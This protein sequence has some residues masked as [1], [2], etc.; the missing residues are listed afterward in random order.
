MGIDVH[1]KRMYDMCYQEIAHAKQ[2][3]VD[4]EAKFRYQVFL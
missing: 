1:E 4:L 3:G 2:K